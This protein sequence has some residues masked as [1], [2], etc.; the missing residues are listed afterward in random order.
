MPDVLLQAR[1]AVGEPPDRPGAELCV[2]TAIRIGHAG[3][4]GFSDRYMDAP[5]GQVFWEAS[6]SS[7]V[8]WRPSWLSAATHGNFRLHPVGACRAVHAG[9]GVRCQWLA[10]GIGPLCPSA[11]GS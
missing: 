9:A 5:D 2:A 11:D 3:H 10:T 4:S 8:S 1:R 7:A 6:P